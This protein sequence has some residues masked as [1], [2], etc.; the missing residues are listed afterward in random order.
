ML[1]IYQLLWR[2]HP[3]KVVG[4]KVEIPI[5]DHWI[6]KEGEILKAP[7]LTKSMVE[8]YSVLGLEKAAYRE[9]E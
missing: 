5:P 2:L 1:D 8:I 3:G 4:H 6:L 9:R 7:E